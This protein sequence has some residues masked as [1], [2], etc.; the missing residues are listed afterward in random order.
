M[1]L[2]IANR[3]GTMTNRKYY[4]SKLNKRQSN[5]MMSRRAGFSK[6]RSVFCRRSIPRYFQTYGYDFLGYDTM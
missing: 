4:F 5:I 6:H 2:Y 3:S 1:A